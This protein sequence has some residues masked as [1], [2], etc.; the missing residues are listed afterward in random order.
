[1][2][3][4]SPRINERGFGGKECRYR[5]SA[6]RCGCCYAQVKLALRQGEVNIEELIKS[7]SAEHLLR[8]GAYMRA[9]MEKPVRNRIAQ[10][11]AYAHERGA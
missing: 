1:M 10:R 2:S 7:Y 9:E 3:F 4:G 11:S 8:L 5:T 6:P